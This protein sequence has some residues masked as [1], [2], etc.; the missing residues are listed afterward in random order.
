MN[1]KTLLMATAMTFAGTMAFAG[2]AVTPQPNPLYVDATPNVSTTFVGSLEYAIEAETFEATAG[3]E[4]G[5]DQ[6]TITPVIV[7]NDEFGDFDFSSAEL[8]VSY[9]ASENVDLYI[10]FE[11]D[12]D[13]DYAETTLGVAFR[14]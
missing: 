2:G 13:F 3:M 6:W 7:M 8:N 14:F 1:M 12:A 10:T 5:I 9:D 11:T 4:F